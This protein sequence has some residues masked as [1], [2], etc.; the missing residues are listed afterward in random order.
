MEIKEAKSEDIKAISEVYKVCFPREVMHQTWVECTFASHPRSTYFVARIGN[1]IN[2]YI[3][4]SFKNGFRQGSILELEQIGVAP[5]H[6]GKGIASTLI[7]N[8]YKTMQS[9]AE[10][11]GIS[12]SRILVTTRQGNIA[13]NIYKKHLG[14]QTV[15][16]IENYGSGNELILFRKL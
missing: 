15:A 2:G 11:M 14:V 9:L 10:S 13:E 3:L 7:V 12:I 5:E 6:S 8:T 4:W 1:T 16:T